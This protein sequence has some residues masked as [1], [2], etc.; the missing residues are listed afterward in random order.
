MAISSLVAFQPTKQQLADYVN[1][2]AIVNNYAYGI[3]NQKL[4][5][6]NYPPSN[7]AQFATDFVPAKQHAL[8]W[9]TNTF[10]SMLQF[11]KTLK[12]QVSNL[13]NLEESMVEAYLNILIADPTNEKAK[14]GL[15][16]SLATLVQSITAQKATVETIE[17]SL[18]DFITNIA[19]DSETL[20]AIA[21]GALADAGD[22][23]TTIQNLQDNINKLNDEISTAQ[24]LLTVSEIGIG[25]SIFVA[26]I[27]A[28]LLA[29]PGA[30][31]A[32]VAIIV[33]GVGGTAA[34][35]AG[36]VIETERIK[37]MQ[38][39]ISSDQNQISGLNKDIVVLNAVSTQFNNL[40]KASL[41]AAE[42]LTTIKSMWDSLEEEIHTLSTELTD[43]NSDVSS[44]N[45]QK[46]LDDFQT[47]ETN[48]TDVLDFAEALAGLDFKWQDSSGNWHSYGDTNPSI[49]NGNVNT[50]AKAA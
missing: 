18:A 5:V 39:E 50:I 38:A 20:A 42:A 17:K 40:Y 4:P 43:V 7:Y 16:S 11:P 22:D 36:T 31:G 35:I 37:A 29:V 30:Q 27:G 6:L 14:T 8:N 28:V 19:S 23:K 46:A 45:Y 41:N 9:T 49:D 3:T 25:L 15:A 24:T 12:D 32:G 10:P 2:I 21:K 1:A 34:S 47:A 13:F 48:W 44:A 26:L 33:V